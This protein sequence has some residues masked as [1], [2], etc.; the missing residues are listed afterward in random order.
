[1][2]VE[3]T[4]NA[5]TVPLAG[6]PRRT[7]GFSEVDL[8]A[9]DRGVGE[10][11]EE[12]TRPDGVDLLFLTLPAS[13]SLQRR[14]SDIKEMILAATDPYVYGVS[15]A[16][17]PDTPIPVKIRVDPQSAEDRF[18]YTVSR[19]PRSDGRTQL[20]RLAVIK[21]KHVRVN[22]DLFF[23][24]KGEDQLAKLLDYRELEVDFGQVPR[25]RTDR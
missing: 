12:V 6:A 17:P 1:V 23:L 11:I 8:L 4:Q 19:L 3:R 13:M 7:G 9:S 22:A 25:T 16:L 24:G 5:E 21:T 2:Q 18:A 14:R 10:R 20:F 15:G